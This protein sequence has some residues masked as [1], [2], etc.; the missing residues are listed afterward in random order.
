MTDWG[1]GLKPFVVKT[2]CFSCL[3]HSVLPDPVTEEE[4]G[5]GNELTPHVIVIEHAGIRLP[6]AIENALV[7]NFKLP[8]QANEG[9]SEAVGHDVP[10]KEKFIADPFHQLANRFR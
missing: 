9:R 1:K 6:R 5:I 3:D 8:S 4:N 7:V 10:V 2:D